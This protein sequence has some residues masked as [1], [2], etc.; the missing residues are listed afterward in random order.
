MLE[1]RC[2][3]CAGPTIRGR[4]GYSCLDAKCESKIQPLMRST[5][6]TDKKTY[7][8]SMRSVRLIEEINEALERSGMTQQAFLM[9]A[10]DS[11]LKNLNNAVASPK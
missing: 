6:E 7:S 3:V 4:V 11:A 5:A 10:I 1:I 8:V 9:L 2:R